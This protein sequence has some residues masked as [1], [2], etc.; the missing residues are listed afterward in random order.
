MRAAPATLDTATPDAAPLASLVFEPLVRLD[1]SG[2]PHPC[3]AISWQHDATAKRWQFNLRPGV[4]FH[5]GFALVPAAVVASLRSVLAGAVIGAAGDTITIRAE[6]PGPGLLLELAHNGLVFARDAEGALVG[7]GPFRL[8]SWEPGR[9]ATL[10]ASADYWGGRAFVDAIEL[11]MGRGLRE[12]LVD[13]EIGKTD[14]AELGPAELR[15]AAEHGRAV[16]SSAPLHLIAL[17]FAPGHAADPRLRE[18]LAL[19]IDRAAMHSVLLQKQGEITAAL[20]PQWLSGYA[21]AFPT[22]PDPARARGLT[23]ELPASARVLALSYDPAIPA[24]RAICERVAVNAR[25]AGL[26]VQVAPQNAKAD[27][28]LVEVRLPSLNAVR[29]LVDIGPS[30]GLEALQPVGPT[31][32]ALYESERRLLEDFRAIPL[33]QLPDLYGAAGRVH[34]FQP[35]AITRMGDWRFENIW[36]SGAA[37]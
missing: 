21:F 29:A 32:E 20:L 9:R 36:L 6:R 26:T 23:A 17:V 33:F 18:A 5:D 14:I 37:P 7:T 3:L 2:A 25:D 19:S 31:P 35:P 30:I 10:A 11:Q 34:V 8:A 4:K 13:L 22:A 27:L 24:G 1:A 12:Q 28:N 15:R 16:W